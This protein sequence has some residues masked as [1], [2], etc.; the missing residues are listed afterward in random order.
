M[1][2]LLKLAKRSVSSI[3]S[4]ILNRKQGK[5]IQTLPPSSRTRSAKRFNSDAE[6]S[7]SH[8]EDDLTTT[9]NLNENCGQLQNYRKLQC[10]DDICHHFPWFS[11]NQPCETSLSSPSHAANERIVTLSLHLSTGTGFNKR[12]QTSKKT[13]LVVSRPRKIVVAEDHHLNL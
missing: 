5:Q 1:P 11:K 2:G 6:S 13:W 10:L 7:A 4:C 12:H 9:Q 8:F 3:K